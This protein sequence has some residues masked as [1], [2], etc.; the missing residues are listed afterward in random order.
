[1]N[2]KWKKAK[3]D[4]K[5]NNSLYS[6]LSSIASCS[7][8]LSFLVSLFL[9]FLSLLTH[10]RPITNTARH[11]HITLD[12]R[13]GVYLDIKRKY[14]RL[15]VTLREMYRGAVYLFIFRTFA[16]LWKWESIRERVNTL[17]VIDYALWGRCC[18]G[19]GGGSGK[20]VG[21]IFIFVSYYF[22]FTNSQLHFFRGK[23]WWFL[24]SR[25][26]DIIILAFT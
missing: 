11:S 9:L 23:R 21:I 16:S 15:N 13:R 3:S 19:F 26:H 25:F 22:S 20:Y 12:F 5:H 24:L 1:M 4:K 18:C 6:S 8:T 2:S 10:I 14:E 7:S 17:Y